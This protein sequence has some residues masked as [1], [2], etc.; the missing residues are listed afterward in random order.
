MTA[1]PA[2]IAALD[3]PD[4]WV[5]EAAAV[6]LRRITGETEAPRERRNRG[7][8]QA[9]PVAPA[10]QNLIDR[11]RDPASRWMAIVALGEMGSE[12]RAA[13]PHL[14]EALEDADVQVRW[15]AAKTLGKIGPAAG[16]ADPAP[17]QATG[18]TAPGDEIPRAN[19][20]VYT[21]GELRVEQGDRVIGPDGWGGSQA[22][23]IFKY[24][25][26]R[27]TRRL[28]REE[29]YELFFPDSADAAAS[30]MR[31]TVYRLRRILEPNVDLADSV[32]VVSRDGIALRRDP[33]IWIDS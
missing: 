14:I 19:L 17:Q 21:L 32:I 2:L 24:L 1:K 15:D 25:I 7:P 27:R 20:R 18:Q 28:P 9:P 4:F 13:V 5:G 31:S 16:A 22:R 29:A 26:S 10:L 3:D 30:T 11:M 12:A 23:Q 33:P 8:R 6:A